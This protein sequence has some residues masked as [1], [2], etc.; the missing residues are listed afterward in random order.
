MHP[1]ENL[2]DLYSMIKNEVQESIHIDY[3][4]SRAL[5]KKKL[6]EIAKDVS[7]FANS[8][9]GVIVYGI[10]EDQ[11]LPKELDE[12]VDHNIL[13]REWLENVISSNISPIIDG[14][15]WS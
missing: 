3:K 14:C 10:R 6:H 5:N 2:S 15:R 4:D 12:G 13:T 8:D 7:A 1:P 11:H 9:G